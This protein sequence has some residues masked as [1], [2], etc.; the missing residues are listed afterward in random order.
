MNNFV[1][2]HGRVPRFY[3]TTLWSKQSEIR[4]NVKRMHGIHRSIWSQVVDVFS[5][6]SDDHLEACAMMRHNYNYLNPT[7]TTT[8]R[9][10][11]VVAAAVDSL[12]SFLNLVV[13]CS[14]RVRLS[15]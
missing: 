9:A 4:S 8:S 12:V 7:T 5:V 10:W 11:V 2:V 3:L 6:F 13:I 14:Y 15:N 1:R